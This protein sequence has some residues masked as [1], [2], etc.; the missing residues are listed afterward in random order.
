M[1]SPVSV[2][3][4]CPACI[5]RS[6]QTL[7]VRLCLDEEAALE[8][9]SFR[10]DRKAVADICRFKAGLLIHP[11][12]LLVQTLTKFALTIFKPSVYFW[13][14]FG[15]LQRAI[16]LFEAATVFRREDCL[17]NALFDHLSRD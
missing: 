3:I 5:A 14:S 17:V 15:F 16:S 8:M 12:F 1:I 13:H 7:A 10:C 6:V 9:R 4:V 11:I 2:R